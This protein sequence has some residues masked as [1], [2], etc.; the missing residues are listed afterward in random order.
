MAGPSAVSRFFTGAGYIGRALGFVGRNRTLWAWVAAPMLITTLG[1][2]G[3]V[4]GL[5]H[6]GGAFV[7]GK[8]AGHGMLLGFFVW[9]FFWFLLLAAGIV[10]F[11]AL[12]SIGTAPFA[13]KISEKTERL[14]TGALATSVNE[15]GAVRGFGQTLIALLVYLTS[16]LCVLALDLLVAPLSPLWM[17]LGF[18]FTGMYLAYDNLDVPLGRRGLDVSGKWAYLRTHRAETLGFGM[19][20]AALFLVPGLGLVV[21]AV[22]VTAGTLLC[23]DLERK[24]PKA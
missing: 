1:T 5:Y 8:M 19:T 14:A 10:A 7:D 21:P 3:L 23:I 15:V 11:I 12:S 13:S 16:A 22:A 6:Y 4:W 17:L 18:V 20:T 2:V 9:L 24:S